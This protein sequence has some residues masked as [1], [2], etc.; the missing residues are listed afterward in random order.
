MAGLDKAAFL[1]ARQ[2][3]GLSQQRLADILRIERETVT[4]W[5]SGRQGPKSV[6]KL[7]QL[8]DVLGV[9]ADVLLG[10]EKF[11]ST[12]FLADIIREAEPSLKGDLPE[13]LA[14]AIRGRLIEM[15][16]GIGG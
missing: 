2:R 14:D 13:R 5:E 3:K 11:P 12:R 9:S 10:R 16:G 4:E 6:D 15:I 1:A 7:R 8:C